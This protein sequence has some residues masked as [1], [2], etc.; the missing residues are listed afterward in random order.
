MWY[1]SYALKLGRMAPTCAW[2]W[3]R[4]FLRR[5]S[6]G[7]R[8][9][10]SF[11][12]CSKMRSMPLVQRRNAVVPRRSPRGKPHRARRCARR[13]RSRARLRARRQ[14]CSVWTN[15]RW[16]RR[17]RRR[18]SYGVIVIAGGAIGVRRWSTAFV[19]SRFSGWIFRPPARSLYPLAKVPAKS[20]GR[21]RG[22]VKLAVFL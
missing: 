20:G 18:P 22:G 8:S 9:S 1:H 11:S 14:S 21:R 10:R 7:L 12:I 4:I 16:R 6:I 17:A 15:R 2:R 19:L 3:P 13:R 5:S